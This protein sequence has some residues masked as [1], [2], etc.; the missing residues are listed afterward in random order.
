[1]S[2]FH[3]LVDHIYAT[4]KHLPNIGEVIVVCFPQDLFG[5]GSTLDSTRN[6][7]SHSHP[8]RRNYYHAV[9]IGALRDLFRSTIIF[10][11]LPMPD[12][13]DVDPISGLS[14]TSW[15]LSQPVDYQ[16]VHIPVPYEQ[17]HPVTQPHLPF[18]TPAQFGDPIGAG[19]WKDDRPR[20]IQDVPMLIEVEYTTKVCVEFSLKQELL[21]N[22]SGTVPVLRT[23]SETE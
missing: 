11:V 21:T 20:W 4:D 10:T 7:P 18:P 3:V 13:S 5:P 16:N 12:Y 1:M 14:S 9:V 15:L 2:S 8:T 17:I 19:G 6:L 23:T 22:I